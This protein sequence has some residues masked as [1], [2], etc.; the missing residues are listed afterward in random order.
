MKAYFQKM[1]YLSDATYE[2]AVNEIETLVR[3]PRIQE[4]IRNFVEHKRFPWE[5]IG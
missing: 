3:D 5:K 2:T 1:W 4:S